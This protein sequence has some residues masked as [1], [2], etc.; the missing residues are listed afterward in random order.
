MPRVQPTFATTLRYQ[1]TAS[2]ATPPATGTMAKPATRRAMRLTTAWGVLAPAAAP[3]PLLLGVAAA[4][5]AAP[6]LAAPVLLLG[7]LLLLVTPALAVGERAGVLGPATGGSAAAAAASC[8]CRASS[9]CLAICFREG[10]PGRDDTLPRAF[11]FFARGGAAS[12]GRRGAA[13]RSG[14]IA[15]AA[16]ATWEWQGGWIS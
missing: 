5:A 1:N 11:T 13:G 16:G 14:A 3:V 2:D 12:A 7:A 8:C 15:P 9:C 10:G 6:L 4:A